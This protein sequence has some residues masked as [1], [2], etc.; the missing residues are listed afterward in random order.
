VGGKHINL[1]S[2][3]CELHV[4]LEGGLCSVCKSTSGEVVKSVKGN[5]YDD[6]VT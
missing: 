6:L 4:V 3:L 2:D 5:L 1:Y